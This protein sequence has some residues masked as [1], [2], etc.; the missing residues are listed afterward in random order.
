[1]R[2]PI[3]IAPTQ[4][5][6]HHISILLFHMTS[7]PLTILFVI[8]NT[9]AIYSY[10]SILSAMLL[11]G[12]RVEASFERLEENWTGGFYLEPL[13]EFKR[14][15]PAFSYHW[16]YQRKD[17][18]V[19]ALQYVRTILS[20]RRFL[21]VSGQSPYYRDRLVSYLPLPLSL[22]LR[23]PILGS[24]VRFLLKR[25][26]AGAALWFLEHRIPPSPL[27][28]DQIKRI[29]PDVVVASAGNLILSSADVEYLKAASSLG[30]PTVF[31]VISWDYLATKGIL[32]SSIDEVLVWNEAQRK[33]G[34]THHGLPSNRMVTTGA[35]YFDEWFGP[36]GASLT[37]HEFCARHDLRPKDP[38]VVYL[39]SS[40]NMAK[41]ETGLVREI[42]QAFDAHDDPRVRATQ[43][44]V[45]PHPANGKIYAS[46]NLHDVVVIPE[47]G[48]LPDHAASFQLFSDTLSHVA[49]V[50][51]GVNTTAVLESIVAGKPCIALL[52]EQYRNTQQD[53]LHFQQLLSADA[54]ECAYTSEE[55]AL[56]FA[57]LLNGNDERRTNRDAFIASYIRPRGLDVSAADHAVD[58]IER[59][60]GVRN[61]R[62]Q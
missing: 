14:A 43:I 22:A 37:R 1:M 41:N 61:T 5:A 2:V 52:T 60:V 10:K 62:V 30:I 3:F 44:I 34:V 36:R 7:H 4:P 9:S 8:R 46:L 51:V 49:A 32:P 35:F 56:R 21:C 6:P 33:E 57:S 29:S 11:R 31:P 38:I 16:S 42:R 59:I 15:F 45:R 39:G 24:A 53:T 54:L 55:V 13:K 28:I 12:H 50:I 48:A 26:S 20:Y 58:E 27:L 23:A 18:W 19:T 17:F 47:G 25:N 40:K